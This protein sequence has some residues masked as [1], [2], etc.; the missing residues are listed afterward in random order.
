[1]SY[2]ITNVMKRTY[3][4][5]FLLTV[6]QMVNQFRSKV[7]VKSFEGISCYFDYLGEFT[8]RKRQGSGADTYLHD[9]SF[10]RRVCVASTYDLA[11]LLDKADILRVA[12]D[13]T[14]EV[15]QAFKSGFEALVDRI[16]LAAAIADAWSVS[17]EDETRATVSLG[18]GQIITETGTTGLTV[19]KVRQAMT[20]LNKNKVPKNWPR[21]FALSAQGLDDLLTD[22]EITLA[23]EMALQAIQEGE[24][25]KVFG[26]DM[27]MSEE[28]PLNASTHIRS[29][30]A[31]VKNGIGLGVLQD[32]E[33]DLGP[34]RDKNLSKQ[35][36]A[37]MDLG[38]TR[39][40]EKLVVEVR[41]YDTTTYA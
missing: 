18:A 20:I 30:V 1:M 3:A 15:M 6:R 17:T 10:S 26:F 8:P 21:M 2:E 27:F 9:A 23:Q 25:K 39:V 19:A 11:V 29:N 5:Y 12:K 34:R 7:L 40:E 4:E 22:P 14:S 33:T 38:A 36:F 35:A 31:W 28:T 32:Y 37:S 41:A 16:I 24:I 13:P